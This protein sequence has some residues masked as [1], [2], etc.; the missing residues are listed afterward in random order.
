MVALLLVL[1]SSTG[2]GGIVNP[3][4]DNGANVMPIPSSFFRNLAYRFWHCEGFYVTDD[5]GNS[6][7]LCSFGMHKIRFIYAA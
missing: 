4:P 2:V 3:I 1:T 6:V 7:R 5:F